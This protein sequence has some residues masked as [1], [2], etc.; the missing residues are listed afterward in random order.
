MT[1]INYKHIALDWQ[2]DA[3]SSRDFNRIL[4][5]ALVITALLM[6]ALS[7]I[8]VPEK[9]QQR[10]A[11]PDRIA[12]FISKKDK[13]K[14]IPKPEKKPL[15]PPPKPEE[16]K[17][18]EKPEVV[19]EVTRE[20][21]K[22]RKPLTEAE[23]KARKTAEK[24][25]LLALANELND[26]IDTKD[27]NNNLAKNLSEKPGDSGGANLIAGHG[28]DAISGSV[29]QSGGGVDGKQYAGNISRTDLDTRN[30]GKDFTERKN[31]AEAKAAAK[32]ASG[33]G[34]GSVEENVTMVF[35][36][37]KGSL[38][39][40]YERERRVTQGIQGKIV[41]QITISPTGDVTD[42]K[43]VSS[44]LNSPE[45]E[46]KIVNRV[47]TFKFNIGGDKSITLNYP[48]EFLPS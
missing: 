47:R 44:E 48:I 2:P 26:L 33:G 28:T 42:I 1:A 5:I 21:D 8:K 7:V 43:I 37:N 41:L 24:S 14:V 9:K 36:K 34:G 16:V 3:K 32:K 38:Y 17:P 40:L 45:L 30:V 18:V 46:S 25:G 12:N 23:I 29:A 20:R 4:I 31:Q 15:P 10:A 11:V 35:D 27:L 19:Q 22:E 13:P 6:V 39:S